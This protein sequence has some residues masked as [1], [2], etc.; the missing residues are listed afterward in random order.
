MRW[1]LYIVSVIVIS[2]CSVTDRRHG[3]ELDRAEELMGTSPAEAFERLNA[4]DVASMEDSASVA[5]WALLYSEAMAANRLVAPSDSIVDIAV[6]YYRRK[7]MSHELA[8]SIQAKAALHDVRRQEGADDLMAARY[9]Q[10]EKEYYLYRERVRR[11]RLMWGAVIVVLAAAAGFLW[12]WQR[13]RINRLRTEALMAEAAGLR[14]MLHDYRNDVSCKGQKLRQLL[15][16]RFSLIDSLCGTY[17]ES[18]GTNIERKALAERV[19]LEIEALKNDAG[20][21]AEMEQTVNDCRDNLL[22]RLKSDYP[23]ISMADYRL[24]VYLACGFSNR[25][26]SLLSGQSLDVV[27]K[28]KSRL[29]MKLG[30]ISAKTGNDFAVIFNAR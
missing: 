23:T 26:I 29:K 12:L 4:L 28:R 30:G 6:G 11:E 21:F 8:R 15:S 9:T 2:S 1:L 13:L 7:D 20:M 19:R 14:G 22:G 16:R 17:Y 10:K 5:R 18:Q 24:A 3:R 25:A 27:Y